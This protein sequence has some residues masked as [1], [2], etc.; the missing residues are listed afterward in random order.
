MRSLVTKITIIKFVVRTKVRKFVVR[1]LV[2]RFFWTEVHTTNRL[3]S[4]YFADIIKFVV[5]TLVRRFF[6][7]R[8]ADF[9]PQVFLD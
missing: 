8:S 6:Q 2:R 1:T 9:S 3:G 4:P 7:V 5:R